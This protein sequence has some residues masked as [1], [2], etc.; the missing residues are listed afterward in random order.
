MRVGVYIGEVGATLGGAFTFQQDVLQALIS[1][2]GTSEHDFVLLGQLHE[3]DAVAARAAGFEIAELKRSSRA[4][5]LFG[6]FSEIVFESPLL[7]LR[8]A[9]LKTRL[10][11]L[12]TRL[13]LDVVWF[14]T[15]L[16]EPTDTPYIFTVWDLQH[17]AQPWFPEVSS[18]GRWDFREKTYS[19]VIPRALKVIA[20]NQAARAE[21]ERFYHVPPERVMM[22]PHPTPAFARGASDAAEVSI[23]RFGLRNPFVLYPAQF[24]PHKNHV[25]L[26][27]AVRWF[28]DHHG[29]DLDIALVGH[30]WGN[31][32]HVE[33]VAKRLGLEEHTKF[34]GFVSRPE[35]VALYRKA[36]ALVYLTFFGPENLP[37]LEAFALR[38]PVIVAR[39]A[40]A[41]EQLGSA[42]LLVDPTDAAEVGAAIHRVISDAELRSQLLERGT[43]RAASWSPVDYVTSVMQELDRFAPIRACWGDQRMPIA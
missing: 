35:L 32:A 2:A 22:L 30:N 4:A 42:A 33:R 29:I 14:V 18:S 20:S 25:G 28:K 41:E 38:C 5:S 12:V 36:A 8:A 6:H 24:W 15:P 23:E 34:L 21:L 39:Y 37:P 43:T 9:G 40:G 13:R 7:L 17:R 26:L 16:Y 19:R 3:S 1:V 10:D 27:R 31:R 11:R